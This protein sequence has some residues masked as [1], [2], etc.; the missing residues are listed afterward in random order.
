M[1]LGAAAA[2]SA[3]LCAGFMGRI[4]N[5]NRAGLGQ[6]A[7]AW[8]SITRSPR[9][10]RRG[11]AA[12]GFLTRAPGVRLPAVSSSPFLTGLNHRQSEAVLHG[13]GPLVD[14]RRRRQRQ[15]AGHHP[16]CRPARRSEREVQPWRI[17]AVTFTN[18]AAGRAAAAAR[19]AG[20]GQR[21]RSLG[22]ARSTPSARASCAATPSS[23]ACARTSSSTTTP[24][25]AR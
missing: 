20:A 24:I 22:R 6:N 9:L 19:G 1:D 7:R 25:S 16:P 10:A 4:C 3:W 13:E 5:T 23:P 2:P 11:R 18:K 15:D 17:L 8:K 21:A 12:W 14:L